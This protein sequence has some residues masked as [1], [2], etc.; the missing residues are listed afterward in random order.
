MTLMIDRPFVRLESWIA[1][2]QDVEIPVLRQTAQHIEALS[3][4]EEFNARKLATVVLHDPLMILR[5]FIYIA[6]HR[7]RNQQRD[8]T[9]V[10][11]AL[12]M[13]GMG[14]FFENFS[15]LPVVEQQL[16]AHPKALVAL[17][18]VVGRGRHASRWARDWAILRRDPEVEEL[19]LA[20]LLHDFAE[21]L[22]WC[23]SPVLANRVLERQTADKTL[24]SVAVQQEEYGVP[25][26]RIKKVMAEHWCLPGMLV[27]LMD[28]EQASSVRVRNVKLAID[29]ARHTALGWD[30]AALNDDLSAIGDLLHLRGL[31]LLQRLDAPEH[32]LETARLALAPAPADHLPT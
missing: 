24:R 32:V 22:M 8:I 27:A 19:T 12:L 11:A 28:P 30:N 6:R 7:G 3:K 13:I 21:L 5:L 16:K 15:A 9:T 14:P 10:E 29:L 18:R 25:L 17:L 26:Y 23:F 4:R 20:A 1:Y 2:F 31:P